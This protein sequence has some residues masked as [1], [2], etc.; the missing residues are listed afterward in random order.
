MNAANARSAKLAARLLVLVPA[1]AV[2]RSASAFD[3]SVVASAAAG[4]DGS[5]SAPYNH[6]TDALACVT[7][8][9]GGQS[10]GARAAATSAEAITIHASGTFT[11]SYD[12]KQLAA[13]PEYEPGPLIFRFPDVALIGD[14]QPDSRGNA[15][16]P[17]ALSGTVLATA[18]KLGGDQSV[19]LVGPIADLTTGAVTSGDR[20]T[21]AHL[22]LHGDAGGQMITADR[23][24]DLTIANM[25]IVGGGFGINAGGLRG[26][27]L[28]DSV[29]TRNGCGNCI[30][31][32]RALGSDSDLHALI[33]GN[34]MTSNGNGG[35]LLNPGPRTS[36]FSLGSY[37]ATLAQAPLGDEVFDSLRAVVDGNVLSDN[38]DVYGFSFGLR[39]FW[40]LPLDNSP[41]PG[42]LVVTVTNNVVHNNDLG[43][44]IDAGFPYRSFGIFSGYSMDLTFAGNDV[45]DNIDAPALVDFTRN[46]VEVGSPSDD[47]F[48]FVHDSRITITTGPE[49]SGY[50][51]DNPF[52][53]PFDGST[54]G[55]H[56]FVNG[57]E[58]A[59]GRLVPY[60]PQR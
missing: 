48:G 1:L 25:T 47:V 13:H 18:H 4:G 29:I 59:P 17:N 26:Y 55:N 16:P 11:L 3:I 58:V 37:S 5:V 24:D 22:Y 49:L 54:L 31:A 12:P 23:V 57:A 39:L 14:H 56:L 30:T 7:R 20:V 35:L 38:H 8:I 10:C 50:A 9:R 45:A 15:N 33:S 42:S 19:I 52:V 32:G 53:D 28:L 51:F 34:V 21:I 44:S 27:R 6:L 40:V 60:G 36:S 2:G 46:T 43:F 41:P